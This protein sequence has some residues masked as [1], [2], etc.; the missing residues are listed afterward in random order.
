MVPEGAYQEE[1][2][3]PVDMEEVVNEEDYD[4]DQ[5]SEEE[6][7][8]LRIDPEVLEELQFMTRNI[9]ED[10]LEATFRTRIE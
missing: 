1:P 4:S 5:D 6:E 10:Q 3:S 7:G 8:G 2:M 9:K